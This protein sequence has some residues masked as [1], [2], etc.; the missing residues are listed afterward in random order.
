MAAAGGREPPPTSAVPGSARGPLPETR[1]RGGAGPRRGLP[2]GGA[3][4]S[5]GAGEGEGE[6]RRRGGEGKG[7]HH[8]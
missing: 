6:P 8:V 1:G 2:G 3:R 7:A 4:E 5:G